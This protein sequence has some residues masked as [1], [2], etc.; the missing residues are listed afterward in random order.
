MFRCLTALYESQHT[1][2]IGK[3]YFTNP[4]LFNFIISY[5]RA[6]IYELL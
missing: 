6:E 2:S 4:L 5:V 1:H 3:L